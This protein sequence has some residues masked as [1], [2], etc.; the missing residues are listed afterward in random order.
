M[1]SFEAVAMRLVL[2]G[3]DCGVEFVILGMPARYGVGQ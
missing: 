1:D 3:L 2:V